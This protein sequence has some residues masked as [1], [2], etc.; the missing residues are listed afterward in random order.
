MNLNNWSVPV[1]FAS[2]PKD[3]APKE[4]TPKVGLMDATVLSLP[5]P[6][7]GNEALPNDDCKGPKPPNPPNGFDDFT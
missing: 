5:N 3:G 4:D 1:V 7:D 6:V 2:V